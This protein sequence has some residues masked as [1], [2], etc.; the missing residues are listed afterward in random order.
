MNKT[1]TIQFLPSNHYKDIGY[2]KIGHRVHLTWIN[3]CIEDST[4][5]RLSRTVL[6]RLSKVKVEE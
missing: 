5:N 1:I 3:G 2:I 4:H 6:K